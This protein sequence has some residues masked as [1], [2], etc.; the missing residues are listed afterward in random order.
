MKKL[1]FLPSIR[2]LDLG[3]YQCGKSTYIRSFSKLTHME[4]ILR[5]IIDFCRQQKFIL[6]FFRNHFFKKV[7]PIYL[8][9]WNLKFR[10]NFALLRLSMDRNCAF[11]GWEHRQGYVST[12]VSPMM[13]LSKQT[14]WTLCKI[15]WLLYLILL[16]EITQCYRSFHCQ[17]ILSLT[18]VC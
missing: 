10:K 7:S 4:I 11:V 3:C 8:F 2:I 13:R 16:Q 12:T 9:I 6:K 5:S 15:N 18:F 14:K 17:R 1:F